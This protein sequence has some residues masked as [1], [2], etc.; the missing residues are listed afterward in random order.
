[1]TIDH[2]PTVRP[3]VV[4]KG[5]PGHRI[6]ES[7]FV[8]E[9]P[10]G[11]RANIASP[12]VKMAETSAAQHLRDVETGWWKPP[13]WY[14]TEDD[15]FERDI[16]Y[17]VEYDEIVHYRCE[18]TVTFEQDRAAGDTAEAIRSAVRDGETDETYETDSRTEVTKWSPK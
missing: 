14:R 18:V 2:N 11:H 10:C 13:G 16:T 12:D 7:N 5:T 6:F 1:M 3:G 9:C 4:G 15:D 8:V 17:V